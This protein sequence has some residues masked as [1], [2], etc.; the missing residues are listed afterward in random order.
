MTLV[1]AQIPDGEYRLLRQ[2][3]LARGEPMKEVVR[4]AIHAYLEDEKVNPED[5][6]FRVFPLGSS[7][8]R[9]HTVGRDH[10]E[11]LYGKRS[12]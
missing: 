5:P 11:Y 8:K 2:R 6:L 10:D 4:R 9:A 7:G 1:Q 3:A 12:R